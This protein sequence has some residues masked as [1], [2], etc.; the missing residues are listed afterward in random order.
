MSAPS[1]EQS[2]ASWN[3]WNQRVWLLD[4]IDFYLGTK[5][6][7]AAFAIN[8]EF[9]EV[10]LIAGTVKSENPAA[11]P[12]QDTTL[13]VILAHEGLVSIIRRWPAHIRH[14]QYVL[15]PDIQYLQSLTTKDA[16][17]DLQLRQDL[18]R[19]QF[20][21]EEADKH[22]QSLRLFSWSAARRISSRIYTIEHPLG[23]YTQ[24]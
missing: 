9:E 19:T 13:A 2:N 8:P 11:P 4:E 21:R 1:P 15:K 23:P 3:A 20:N 16:A 17:F 7:E 12:E 24:S 14:S 10:R 18:S 5:A 22:M 6:S